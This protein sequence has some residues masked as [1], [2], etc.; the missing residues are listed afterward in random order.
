MNTCTLPVDRKIIFQ[1]QRLYGDTEASLAAVREASLV[2]VRDRLRCAL[3]EFVHE[4]LGGSQLTI[5]SYQEGDFSRVDLPGR[6]CL[7][8]KTLLFHAC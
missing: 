5:L 6:T 2:V 8:D 7:R 3:V 4:F 1:R